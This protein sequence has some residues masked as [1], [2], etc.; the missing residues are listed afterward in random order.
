[1]DNLESENKGVF[2]DEL[3]ATECTSN[4]YTIIYLFDEIFLIGHN[5]LTANNQLRG[6]VFNSKMKCI[7]IFISLLR[8]ETIVRNF[9]VSHKSLSLCLDLCVNII[10]KTLIMIEMNNF[11]QELENDNDLR[12]LFITALWFLL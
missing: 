8:L 5:I 2:I 10:S 1:M 4:L 3:A 12:E 6:L 7:K 9:L 11:E